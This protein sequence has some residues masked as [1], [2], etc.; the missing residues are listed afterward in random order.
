I[1]DREKQIGRI[2]EQLALDRTEGLDIAPTTDPGAYLPAVQQALDEN[3]VALEY[4]FGPRQSVVFVVSRRAL[5]VVPLAVRPE[6]LR[7][8]VGQWQLNL[9]TAA[10]AVAS[11]TSLDGLSRN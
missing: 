8:L 10:R 7:K 2:V 6:A 9:A 4:Y 3:A 11:G 1:R 5:A